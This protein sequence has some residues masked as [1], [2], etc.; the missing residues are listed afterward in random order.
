MLRSFKSSADHARDHAQRSWQLEQLPTRAAAIAESLLPCVAPLAT[1]LA[2]LRGTAWR[3]D[4]SGMKLTGKLPLDGQ[5]WSHL[6]A[7]QE[8]D[9]ANNDVSGFV[10]PQLVRSGFMPHPCLLHFKLDV[11]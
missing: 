8:L 3:R 2:Q 9:L 5:L 10:P 11:P 4:L 7:L 1:V 6:P